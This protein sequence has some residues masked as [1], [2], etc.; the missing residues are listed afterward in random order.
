LQ[1]SD[2]DCGKNKRDFRKVDFSRFI[3][4]MIGPI[5]RRGRGAGRVAYY[6]EQQG[7]AD[8]NK[9]IALG[10]SRLDKAALVAARL[11]NAWLGRA[12]RFRLKWHR[13]VSFQRSGTRRQGRIGRRRE[14]ISA[15]DDFTLRRIFR[16]GVKISVRPTLA[17]Q[18]GRHDCLSRST[19]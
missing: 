14:K 4:I 13:R 5:W 8:T 16:P 6:L 15:M 3:P 10:H 18:L 2:Q 19:V 7:F 12:R 17:R 9:F 1:F 11:M